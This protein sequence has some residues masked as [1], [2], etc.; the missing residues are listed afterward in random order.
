ML[1]SMRNGG[2]SLNNALGVCDGSALV[3][4][5]VEVNTTV[6]IKHDIIVSEFQRESGAQDESFEA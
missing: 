4:G 1:Q 2:E 5:D 6:I 3:L